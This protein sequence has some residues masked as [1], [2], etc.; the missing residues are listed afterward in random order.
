MTN[1]GMS[2]KAV[3]DGLAAAFALAAALAWYKAA[4][5][6]AGGSG[7][8]GYAPSDRNHPYWRDLSD[9]AER[10]QLGMKLNRRAA[11]LTGISALMMSLSW[12]ISIFS[13]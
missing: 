12:L 13:S 6:P 4:H 2:F 1:L 3:F 8:M 7:P 9:M 5:Q 10:I 11:G